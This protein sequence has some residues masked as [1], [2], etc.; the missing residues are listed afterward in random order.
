MI[1]NVI[2][3]MDGTLTDSM[4]IWE[5]VIREGFLEAGVTPPDN[6]KSV[7]RTKTL[8]QSAA[9]IIEKYG[10]KMTVEEVVKNTVSKVMDFYTNRVLT[11]TGVNEFVAELHDRGVRMC[12]ASVSE[13]PIVEAALRRNG[14]LKYIDRIFTTGEVG[15]GKKE[16]HIYRAAMEY[17]GGDY[18]NTVVFEDEIHTIQ[19][20]KNDGFV[21]C[22]VAEN[23]VPEQDQVKKLADFYINN[24]EEDH[25]ELMKFLENI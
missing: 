20:A 2:F 5:S 12:V 17:M 8:Q 22:G 24:F 10:L 11:K 23:T 13:R 25:D 9:Y 3:D 16:P 15:H 7:L 21:V 4:F 19:T 1:K 18:S 6:L 14:I